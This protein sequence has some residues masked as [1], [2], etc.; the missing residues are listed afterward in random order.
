MT[1]PAG[2][3]PTAISLGR[4]AFNSSTRALLV[5]SNSVGQYPAGATPFNAMASGEAGAAV[6]LTVAADATKKHYLLGYTAVVT[7]AATTDAVTVAIKDDTT[8]K[9]TE[10]APAAAPVGSMIKTVAGMPILVNS[11]VNK[12]INIEASAPGGTT[13]LILSAWGY[14]V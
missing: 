12:A 13:V 11:A 1:V 5:D 14:T 3:E 8:A 10:A 4:G 7:V 6:T 9:I 2:Y